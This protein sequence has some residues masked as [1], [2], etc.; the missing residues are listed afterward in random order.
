MGEARRLLQPV[1]A[2]MAALA[3]V[4]AGSA[5]TVELGAARWLAGSA[6][7]QDREVGLGRRHTP[8][9]RRSDVAD[10]RVSR[11]F[12]HGPRPANGLG[13][14]TRDLAPVLR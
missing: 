8:D 11:P 7:S 2:G 12:P 1:L 9:Q 4:L 14:V 13:L 3:M 6:A 10:E 5:A